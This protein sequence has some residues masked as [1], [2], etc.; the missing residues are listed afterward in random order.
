[1]EMDGNYTYPAIIDNSG[2]GLMNWQKQTILIFQQHWLRQL[3][4][5]CL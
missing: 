1:M 2:Q 3:K 4:K 5:N